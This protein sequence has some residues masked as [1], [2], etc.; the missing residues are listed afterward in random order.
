MYAGNVTSAPDKIY[1]E[2]SE[3]ILFQ[4]PVSEEKQQHKLS[5]VLHQN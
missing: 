3:L 5:N 1:V 2:T 4:L